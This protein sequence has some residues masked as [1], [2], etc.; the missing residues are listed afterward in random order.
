[1]KY[2]TPT[3]A[4]R[5]WLFLLSTTIVSPSGQFTKRIPYTLLAESRH[6]TSNGCEKQEPQVTFEPARLRSEDDWIKAGELV[7]DAP[8]GFDFVISVSDVRNPAWFEHVQ[9]PITKAGVMP[10]ATYVIREKGKV[11]LGTFACAMCHTR[12]LPDG[13]IIKG[14]QGNFSIDRANGFGFRHA[15]VEVAR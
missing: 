10:F 8:F 7:F 12:V 2:R 3:R 1:M 6:I 11:E 9:P 13:T 14:A 15:P 4:T 5:R